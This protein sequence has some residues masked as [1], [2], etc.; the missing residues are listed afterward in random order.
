MRAFHLLS[1]IAQ[2]RNA[3]WFFPSLLGGRCLRFRFNGDFYLSAGLEADPVA[4]L[5]GQ[6][7]FDAQ[8]PVELIGPFHCDF[9]MPEAPNLFDD[10][11]VFSTLHTATTV[12][13][14]GY[15]Q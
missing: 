1:A 7:I 4:I 12:Q 13:R 11:F 3:G 6:S 15:W 2:G 9:L 10:T 5:G 8:L 14:D